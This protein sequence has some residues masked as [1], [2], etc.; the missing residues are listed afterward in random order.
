MLGIQAFLNDQPGALK[1]YR[2]GDRT[3]AAIIVDNSLYYGL[4][5]RLHLALL[6]AVHHLLS[7]P[8][9]TPAMIRQPF[10]AAGPAGFAAQIEWASR[11]LR[12]GL[13][14]YERPPT[15]RFT[16]GSTITLTLNQAPESIAVQ[17]FLAKGRTI[18]E[19]RDLAERFNQVFQTYFNNELP[20]L[21][22]GSFD[23]SAPIAPN[24]ED[25]DGF[26]LHPWPNGTRVVHLAY[27][28]HMYPT[29]DSGNDGNDYIVNYTGASNV[30]Y[31]THDGHDYYFPDL[32]VGTPILAAASGVAY[33]RTQPGNGVVIMH[34]GG[35]ETIYWHLDSF[36]QIFAGRVDTN[37]GVSVQAG[38]V[39]GTS[40][41]TG[42]VHGTPHLHFEVRRYGK[43]IDPYG[44]YGD[45]EDPCVAYAGC[46]AGRWLWHSSMLGLYD[47]TPPDYTGDGQIAPDQTPPIG[48]LSVNPPEDL[49]LL[50]H[51][52]GHV[53]Q[54]VGHEFPTIEGSPSM[55][56]GRY[57][58][59]LH[60]DQTD[61]LT[62]PISNNLSLEAGSISLW[63][64]IPEQYP[65]NSI[66]RHYLFAASANA[67][68]SAWIYTNTLALRRDM[69]GP[70]NTPRWDFWT[71]PGEGA[72]G[73]DDLTTP[74]T[75]APGWHHFVITWDAA[76][77]TKA[78]YIDGEPVA[79]RQDVTLP[80]EIGPLLQIGRFTYGMSQS[81][82]DLDELIIY[83]RALTNAE[84]AALAASDSALDVQPA[85]VTDRAVLL[86]TNALDK[87]SGIVAVQ[88][89][90]NGVFEAPQPYYDAFRWQLPAIEG[91]YELAARYFDRTGNSVVVTR[92][93]E[94]N[95]PPRGNAVSI[96]SDE[97]QASLLISATD[98]NQPITMQISQYA[99][100]HDAAWRPLKSRYTWLWHTDAPRQLYTRFRDTDGLTTSAQAVEPAA[101]IYLPIVIGR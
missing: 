74:D 60:L 69:L 56:D 5:P 96:L 8:A 91:E 16:N 58:Q 75:L 36:D 71:M 34:S 44:W 31:N 54:E 76:Q 82:I 49:L 83:D 78:L 92:T 99:D 67:S 37:E 86:D 11:E 66:N 6:E 90:R 98:A 77:G 79:K 51:F 57:G 89:G 62:Y 10:G 1:Q 26:L 27:F 68:D 9:P 21:Y 14:P 22:A 25:D 97:R 23:P 2:D 13:G 53:L 17:R 45:G 101:S 52:D 35:Y 4:S 72:A 42:F 43:Q 24:P 38:T 40:G 63:A 84:A 50:V 55:H 47:F 95:L 12:A 30:Q 80:T 48:T 94:L 70:D 29:V 32:P 65:P 39:I 19:W 20:D 88:L 87:T 41:D 15:I 7:D 93:I 73:R 46:T 33:A 61:G 18:E 64:R 100:F 85:V 3:A 59:S 28:D 81:G